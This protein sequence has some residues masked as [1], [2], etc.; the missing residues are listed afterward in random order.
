MRSSRW[1]T[2]LALGLLLPGTRS[3]ADD[4]RTQYPSFL[5]KSYFS[6]GF[7]YIDYPFSARQLEPGFQVDSVRVRHAAVR[8][9]LLGY[10]LN[11]H[12]AAQVSYMRPVE[13]VGYVNVNDVQATRTVWM[14]L[15]SVTLRA[16]A[17]L[18]GPLS[19]GGE[20]G[21][22]IVTR[23]GFQQDDVFVV[24]NANYGTPVFGGGLRYRLNPSWDL[25]VDALYFP[26]NSGSRQPHTLL[27]SGGFT[28][29]MRPLS[30]AHALANAQAGFPFPRN[31][32][33]ISY[34]TDAAGFGVNRVVS[35]GA[36]PIFWGGIAQVE[37][38]VTVRYERNVFHTRK[39]FSLDLGASLGRW[40]SRADGQTFYTASVFP[41][42][43]LTP[44]RLRA[45][46]F[47]FN[48]SLAGPTTISR[49]LIDGQ[50]TGRHFTFQDFMG[51]GFYAGHNRRVNGEIQIAHYSNGNLFPSNAGV[52]IPLTFSLGYTF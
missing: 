12:F 31:L 45:A 8:V 43:R 6:V 50:D 23:R 1:A 2:A 25:G 11:E 17:P 39:I 38:G 42:F 36:V 52:S 16:T 47:Y 4:E 30:E 22:G 27:V 13:W 9:G 21:F 48:Y 44:L 49:S 28:F 20:A 35:Q 37:R 5:A 18:V 24:K 29:N 3:F 46:D 26:S 19:I 34:T 7:G 10:R 40:T 33:Q 14:N 41:E 32:L 15:A 51:I